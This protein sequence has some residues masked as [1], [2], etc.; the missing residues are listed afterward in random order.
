MPLLFSYGT[1]QQEEVQLSTFGRTLK[2]EKDLL[3]GYE[4]SLVKIEDAAVA[5]RLKKTHHDNVNATGDDW[6][7]VQ[8][9]AFE[10][11]DEELT[12]ADSFEAQFNYKRVDVG[13]A[14]GKHAWVYVH[15]G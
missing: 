2:G 9:T 6:S 4:P 8:G 12:K 7:S 5:E 11:T 15:A 14:S 3:V 10:V 1:L 13:L